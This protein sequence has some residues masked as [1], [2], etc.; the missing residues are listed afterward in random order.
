MLYDLREMS[1]MSEF[2]VIATGTSASHVRALVERVKR[3]LR[4]K[5]IRPVHNEGEET[6]NWVLLDYFDVVVHVF[7][8]PVRRYYNLEKLWGDAPQLDPQETESV[9]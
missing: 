8:E 6:Y 2:F 5:N 4:E 7:R 1:A 3:G 9:E